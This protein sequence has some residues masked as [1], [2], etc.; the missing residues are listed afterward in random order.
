MTTNASAPARPATPADPRPAFF[1]AARTACDVIAAVS[2]AQLPDQTPCS[3]YDVRALLGHLV[4]VLRR[5]TAVASGVPASATP[6]VLTDVP[7]DGWGAAARASLDEVETAWADDAVLAREMELPFGTLPGAAA[8]VAYTG[9]ISTHTW[10]VAIA[11]GQSP[12]WD[13]L[14]LTDALTA[15]RGK[16]PTAER[17]AG[18]PFADAVPVPDDAP[19]IDRLVAWQGRDPHWRPGS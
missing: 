5:V 8:L 16:L 15:L 11:T 3:E 12:A 9:E 14:V 18:V 4:A 2:P 1:T 7:D 10:D 17:P 6:R 19:V 13:E